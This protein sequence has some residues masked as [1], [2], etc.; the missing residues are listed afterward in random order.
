MATTTTTEVETVRARVRAEFEACI[1]E[2]L[3]RLRWGAD[4]LAAHQ[5]DRIRALL[6]HALAHSPFHARRLAGVDADRFELAD[7]PS[8]PTMRKVVMMEGFDEV[9]TDRRLS[10]RLVEH[11]LA[12]STNEPRL[13]LDDYVCLATGG[14]SGLRGVFVQRL[15]E[16]A[17]FGASIMRPA[18]PSRRSTPV[19]SA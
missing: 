12:S 18:W 1:P 16:F 13:L 5:R 8:L 7:L 9:V 3:E 14:S 15:E 11:H 4:R 17:E 6:R 19:V 10:R 2:H